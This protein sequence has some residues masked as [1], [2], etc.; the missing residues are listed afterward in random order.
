M[1]LK[2]LDCVYDIEYTKGALST[3]E[4]IFTFG[5]SDSIT[6]T[7]KVAIEDL[8]KNSLKSSII[9]DTLYHEIAHAILTEGGY[10]KETENEALVEWIGR[11]IKLLSTQILK[12][13]AEINNKNKKK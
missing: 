13:P 12:L 9:Q 7:I 2:L 3:K 6:R 11:N 4:G 5:T 1:E 10:N 8:D